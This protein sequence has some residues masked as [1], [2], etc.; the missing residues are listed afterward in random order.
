MKETRYTTDS[1]S[2]TNQLIITSITCGM[3]L[4]SPAS[5]TGMLPHSCDSL[6]AFSR[7]SRICI[8]VLAYI[9]EHSRAWW[10]KNNTV[11]MVITQSTI[12]SMKE[13]FLILFQ[14]WFWS[15][16]FIVIGK[17]SITNTG[18]EPRTTHM[19]TPFT[20][21]PNLNGNVLKLLSKTIF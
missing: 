7:N 20:M 4:R 10:Y 16:L 14:I 17:H 18:L 5:T 1:W 3:L 21:E 12:H 19:H 8:M 15:H 9:Y 13:T 2:D 6:W 11:L